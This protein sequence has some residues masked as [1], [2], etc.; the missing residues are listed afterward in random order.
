MAVERVD[1]KFAE[2]A[3]NDSRHEEQGDE[4]GDQGDAN[5][6]KRWKPIS[7][8]P[9]RV[10]AKGSMPASRWRVMFLHDGRWRPSTTKPVEMVRAISERLSEAIATEV[11]DGEGAD[12]GDGNRD[13]GDEGGRGHCAGK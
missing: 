10:A 7:F 1:G 3:A 13:G 5:G 11:H 9:L 2:E 6:Q 4:D 12:E 8:A